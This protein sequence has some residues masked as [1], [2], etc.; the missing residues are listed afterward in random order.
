MTED[1]YGDCGS[2]LFLVLVVA[3]APFVIVI[4]VQGIIYLVNLL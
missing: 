3:V 2:C 1:A 4:L